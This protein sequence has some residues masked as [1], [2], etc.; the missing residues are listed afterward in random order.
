MEINSGRMYRRRCYWLRRTLNST[1]CLMV[2]FCGVL[3]GSYGIVT[4]GCA[5]IGAPHYSWHQKMTVEVEVNGQEYAGSSVVAMSARRLP[6]LLP[7]HHVRELDLRGEATVVALPGDR[8]L[9]ALLTYDAYLTGK[10]F[11]D[12]VGGVV[13]KPEEWGSE[14]DE[15]QEVR[16]IAPKDYPLLV[17]FTDINDPKTVKQVD[18]DDLAATF[19]P[20]VSL[21]RITLEITDEPVTEGKVGSVLRWYW[22]YR[23]K[24]FRL[25]GKKCVACPVSSENF[26]DL[27]GT[28]EFKIG[29]KK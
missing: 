12:L 21:K 11:H 7:E 22:D 3:V 24:G 20:G 26:S 10:V 25:N 28:G 15:V 4:S 29:G 18:P 2:V 8:Y 16:E 27:I 5:L 1:P 23:Q 9:F 6:A 19:G 13:T 17:T 14:I